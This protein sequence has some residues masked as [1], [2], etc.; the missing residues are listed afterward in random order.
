MNFTLGRV[1]NIVGE[2]EYAG[3]QHFPVF[4]QCFQKE[5]FDRIVKS[6]G[7]LVK[8]YLTKCWTGPN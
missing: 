8:S 4:P 7:C 5:L 3:Y 2:G 6:Q 1:G